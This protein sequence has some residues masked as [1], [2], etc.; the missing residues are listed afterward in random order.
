MT[1][2]KPFTPDE[3]DALSHRG[4]ATAFAEVQSRLMAMTYRAIELEKRV[5]ELESELA[6]WK[7][8][9]ESWRQAELA[10]QRWSALLLMRL[11]KQL[12]GG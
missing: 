2:P 6:E 11:G 8:T 10:W 1:D 3:L 5:A 4:T 7:A 9:S 12:E